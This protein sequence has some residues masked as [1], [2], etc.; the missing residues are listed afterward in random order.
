[1]GGGIGGGM[2]T[3]IYIASLRLGGRFGPPRLN[4]CAAFGVAIMNGPRDGFID[5]SH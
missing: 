2:R 1:M 5:I 3:Y 4:E